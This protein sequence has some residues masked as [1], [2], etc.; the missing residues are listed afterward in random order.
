MHSYLS[1]FLDKAQGVL[2]GKEHHLKL[3]LT[4]LLCNGHLLIEDVPGVGKTT[5]VQLMS[6]LLG[7]PLSRIQFTNDL[8]P[9]DIIGISVFDKE[10]REFRFLKGPLFGHLILADELNRAS[11]KT[12]SALLQAMEERTVSLDGNT[13]DLEEPFLVIATQ[14]PSSQIGTFPLPESQLDRFFMSLSLDFPSREDER[15]ILL[16]DDI[17]KQINSL[18]EGAGIEE[19]KRHQGAISAVHVSESL[20]NY[21][22]DLLSVGR[23]ELE[24]GLGLSPR[25]GQDALLAAKGWAYLHGKDFVSSH[26]LQQILGP[27]WGHRLGGMRGRKYGAIDVERIIEQTPVD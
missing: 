6:R 2:F 20:I 9:S 26:D 12:Q 22:L 13:Y 19:F 27:V 1:S 24:L 21:L 4:S 17:R 8:L 18:P 3:A 23:R 25:A 16:I 11:P 5:L 15:Q 7:I 10:L 14:N